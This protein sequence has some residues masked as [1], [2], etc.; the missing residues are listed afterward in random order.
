M[1][2][3]IL[4]FTKFYSKRSWLIPQ[5]NHSKTLISQSKNVIQENVQ[6]LNH[7]KQMSYLYQNPESERTTSRFV[8]IS[9]T[10]IQMKE[11]EAIH[12][13]MTLCFQQQL[14]LIQHI[15]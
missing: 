8:Q 4:S 9:W 6:N 13:L 2:M 10:T 7:K 15:S 1:D 5:Q 12:K 14:L 3:Q 11:S